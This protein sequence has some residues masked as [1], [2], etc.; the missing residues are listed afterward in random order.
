MWAESEVFSVRTVLGVWVTRPGLEKQSLGQQA[1]S[2]LSPSAN[3]HLS[4]LDMLVT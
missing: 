2:P 1:G 3:P 4:L